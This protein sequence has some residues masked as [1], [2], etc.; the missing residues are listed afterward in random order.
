MEIVKLI[1]AIFSIAGPVVSALS[2]AVMLRVKLEISELK[3]D[4]E[5]ARAEDKE[6]FQ[7]WAE[8]HF[9]TRARRG[10]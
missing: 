4:I 2:L 8:N 1:A 10:A 6:A 5:K 9:V 7:V 3:L